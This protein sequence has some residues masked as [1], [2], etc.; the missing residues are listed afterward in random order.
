MAVSKRWALDLVRALRSDSQQQPAYLSS[1]E[2]SHW[3]VI[4]HA[5]VQKAD[6]GDETVFE[7]SRR[8]RS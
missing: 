8:G 5:A 6:A 1:V 2:P 3:A 4:E 7:T